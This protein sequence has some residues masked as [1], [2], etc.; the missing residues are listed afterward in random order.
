MLLELTLDLGLALASA[1][2][3]VLSALVERSGPVRLRGWAEEAGGRL[4]ALFER[5]ARFEAFRFLLAALARL[6]PLALLALLAGGFAGVGPAWRVLPAIAAVAVLLT[7][8]EVLNRRLVGWDAERALRQLTFLY[9]LLAVVLL[10]LTALVAP[11]I[12]GSRPIGNGEEE[13][14]EEDDDVSDEEIEAYVA[15]GEP[16]RVAGAFTIDGLGGPFVRGVEGDHHAVVGLSLPLLRVLLAEFRIR[17][18]EL[19]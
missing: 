19:W 6:A 2:L 17:W 7:A 5:P 1:A 9:R 4:L 12:G 18:H 13:E 11:L 10:P 15:T 16:L 14:D 3:M 8:V